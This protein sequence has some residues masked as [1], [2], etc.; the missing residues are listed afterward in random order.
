MQVLAPAGI[1]QSASSCVSRSMGDSHLTEKVTDWITP[2][3]PLRNRKSPSCTGTGTS[4]VAFTGVAWFNPTGGTKAPLPGL[5]GRQ[6]QV[7]ETTCLPGAGAV[8]V[9]IVPE[10]GRRR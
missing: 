2:C 5:V 4:A 10:P 6:E 9:G 8:T 3:G 7:A 1:V